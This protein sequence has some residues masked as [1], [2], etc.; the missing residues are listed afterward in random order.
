MQPLQ[1]D[2]RSP[3]GKDNSITHAAKTGSMLDAAITMG[4]AETDLQNTIKLRATES[5]IV[6]PKPALDV[7]AKKVDY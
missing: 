2:L 5:E 1:Y 7:S 6:A 3:A 4:S